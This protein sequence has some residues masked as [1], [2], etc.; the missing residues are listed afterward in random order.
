MEQLRALLE[1]ME[2]AAEDIDAALE[3]ELGVTP[4]RFATGQS[5]A[6][7]RRYIDDA[8]KAGLHVVF[9]GDEHCVVTYDMASRLRD[10]IDRT[11]FKT[12]MAIETSPPRS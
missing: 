8:R 9:A 10:E 3:G 6:D 7:I 12:N 4:L 2:F 5:W 11:G 1:E